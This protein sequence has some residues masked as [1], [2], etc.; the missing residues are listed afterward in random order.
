MYI[1]QFIRKP[2]IKKKITLTHIKKKELIYV[3]K[4][5]STTLRQQIISLVL[6]KFACKYVKKNFEKKIIFIRIHKH[7]SCI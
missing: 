1:E 7:E 5:F 3:S 2:W 4:I 6:P